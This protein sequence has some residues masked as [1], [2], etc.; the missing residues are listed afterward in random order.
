MSSEHLEWRDTLLSH[1]RAAFPDDVEGRAAAIAVIVREQQADRSLLLIRRARREGDV[2]SGHVAMPGGHA[3]P[4]DEGPISTAARETREEIGLD[5]CTEG[6]LVEGLLPA[7]RPRLPGAPVGYIQPVVWT[8][9]PGHEAF[10][11]TYRLGTSSEVDHAE[12]VSTEDLLL[13]TKQYEVEVA[14]G[15]RITVPGIQLSFGLLWGITLRVC[16]QLLGAHER[17]LV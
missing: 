9:G 13:Q 3:E 7:L 15:Q 6:A 12:W 10:D 1:E 17:P 8:I 16:E 4:T 11:D 5:L 14:E 2:W